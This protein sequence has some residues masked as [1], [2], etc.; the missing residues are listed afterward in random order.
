MLAL[1]PRSLSPGPPPAAHEA[2]GRAA[3]HTCAT[4]RAPA[5]LPRSVKWTVEIDPRLEL[6]GG[7]SIIGDLV[8]GSGLRRGWEGGR[9]DL[10]FGDG[11]GST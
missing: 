9:I 8:G 2:V 5:K 3:R 4:A 7:S 11:T 1:L 6:F 10:A